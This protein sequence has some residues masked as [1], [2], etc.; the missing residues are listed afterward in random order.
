MAWTRTESI[1]ESSSKPLFLVSIGPGHLNMT[2]SSDGYD[3]KLEGM[4]TFIYHCVENFTSF[5]WYRTVNSTR[6]P[7]K[8][9]GRFKFLSHNQTLQILNVR[10]EDAGDY[11]YIASNGT[12]QVTGNFSLQVDCECFY[13]S[14]F[15]SLFF[16]CI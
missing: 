5:I 1:T 10:L 9:G 3:A 13:S 8:E 6:V 4:K 11:F 12:N 15:F 14:F 7:V 2:Q 16:F